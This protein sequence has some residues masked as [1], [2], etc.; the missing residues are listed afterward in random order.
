[1]QL[2]LTAERS[3]DAGYIQAPKGPVVLDGTRTGPS[4]VSPA[5]AGV[6]SNHKVAQK[7]TD[8]CG[9][10]DSDGAESSAI[11]L[12]DIGAVLNTYK[13][14][15]HFDLTITDDAFGFARKTAEIAGEA[16]TDGLY[17]VRTSLPL[18]AG[19]VQ[20]AGIAQTQVASVS[21]RGRG[22]A[23]GGEQPA[24]PD[25]RRCFGRPVS[26][27]TPR[28]PVATNDDRCGLQPEPLPPLPSSPLRA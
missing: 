17:V 28:R 25:E 12:I 23:P 26:R 14:K 16:A 24:G 9:R 2:R 8:W 20:A 7:A 1:V 19:L 18:A 21:D 6:L 4:G 15:K 5:R 3:R 13:M 22:R 10:W 27:R 11:P